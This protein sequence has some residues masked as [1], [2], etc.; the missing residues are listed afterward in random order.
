MGLLYN[1]LYTLYID[2]YNSLMQNQ[3]QCVYYTKKSK[4]GVHIDMPIYTSMFSTQI[5]N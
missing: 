5:Q 1:N 2:T 4:L 3:K